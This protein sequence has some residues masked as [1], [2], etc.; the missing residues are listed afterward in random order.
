[1]E[2]LR[3]VL[4]VGL[5]VRADPEHDLEAHLVE[6]V[7]HRLRIGESAAVEVPDAV[8]LAQPSSIIRTAGGKPLATIARR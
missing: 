1:M 4:P 7:H 8:A 2:K 3:E 5:D 6:L